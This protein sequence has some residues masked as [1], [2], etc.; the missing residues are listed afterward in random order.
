MCELETGM[1]YVYCGE[2]TKK[3]IKVLQ[4]FLTLKDSDKMDIALNMAKV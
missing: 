2:Q 3:I 4:T 1:K